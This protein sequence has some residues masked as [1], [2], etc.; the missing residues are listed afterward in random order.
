MFDF[1]AW[2]YLINSVLLIV[3]EIDSAYWKEWNLFR[4]PGDI[5]GFLIIHLPLLFV[6][7]LGLAL[8]FLNVWAGLIFSLILALSGLFA[9]SAHM[10]FIARGK[11][12]FK[13]SASIAILSATLLVSLIQLPVTL[14]LLA[15]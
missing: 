14:F 7:Q 8:M 15:G 9:F 13:T 10:F 3:H 12:E 1:L 2:I 5:A 6:V 4:L 11:D